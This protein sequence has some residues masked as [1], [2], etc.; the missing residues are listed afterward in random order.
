MVAQLSIQTG[1]IELD[2]EA[3]QSKLKN[4][5]RLGDFKY[6]VGGLTASI[7]TNPMPQT[8]RR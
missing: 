2:F 4:G 3:R 1:V 6:V 5:V 8:E 7:L